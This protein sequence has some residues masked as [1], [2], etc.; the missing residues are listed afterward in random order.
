MR[1]RGHAGFEQISRTTAPSC[2]LTPVLLHV[3]FLS[4]PRT[5]IYKDWAQESL[6]KSTLK[7]RV[8]NQRFGGNHMF[9][10]GWEGGGW[11]AKDRPQRPLVTGL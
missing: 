4:T 6:T 8:Q 5:G 1:D 3:P 7:I 2:Q 11:W 10:K 9:I